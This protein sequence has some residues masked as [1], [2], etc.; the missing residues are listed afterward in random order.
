MTQSDVVAWLKSLSDKRFFEVLYE[1]AEGRKADEYDREWLDRHVVLGRVSRD[2][3]EPASAWSIELV[4]LP[5]TPDN[6]SDD[7]VVAQEGTHCGVA[8]VS[9]AKEFRCPVC[10]EITQGT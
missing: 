5:V 7:E 1:A 6:C 10:G 8:V 2:K 4:G 3:S 9:W